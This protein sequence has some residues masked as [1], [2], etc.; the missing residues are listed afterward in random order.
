[1]D[2]ILYFNFKI[3][4]YF[5]LYVNFKYPFIIFLNK[6]N[7]LMEIIMIHKNY[8]QKIFIQD[9]KINILILLYLIKEIM[10]KL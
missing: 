2:N 4:M 8:N 3:F 6:I 10:E 9:N 5:F 1:M 7:L